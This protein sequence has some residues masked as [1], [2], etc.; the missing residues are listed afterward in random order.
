MN[1]GKRMKKI[2]A[3][4]SIVLA[5]L[6]SGCGPKGQL[7]ELTAEAMIEKFENKET[8][9]FFVGK[10]DCP[11]CAE[12]VNTLERYMKNHDL[13]VYYVLQDREENR[14]SFQILWDTYFPGLEDI[15]ATIYVKDG[16]VV[17]N[18]VASGRFTDE[19]LINWL[20]RIG[21]DT[22]K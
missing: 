13:T 12:H 10:S 20:E 1:K 3:I 22:G 18:Q 4:I 14:N 6:L 21:Y 11:R 5:V 2:F 19:G 8:F 9:I 7:I 16:E 17:K 15:P